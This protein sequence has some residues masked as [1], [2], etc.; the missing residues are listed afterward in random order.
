MPL[1]QEKIQQL[2]ALRDT[3]KVAREPEIKQGPVRPLVDNKTRRCCNRGC[4]TPAYWT[5]NGIPY[6]NIHTVYHLNS[7]IVEQSGEEVVW[8]APDPVDT[9]DLLDIIW[10]VQYDITHD[11]MGQVSDPTIEKIE[12]TMNTTHYPSLKRQLTG[13]EAYRNGNG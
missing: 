11:F 7:I 12:E 5:V 6:C 10:Q 4:M 13:F 9:M 3:P 1:D 8:K 2:L